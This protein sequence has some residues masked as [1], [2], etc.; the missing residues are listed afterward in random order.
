ML[1]IW[2]TGR[3]LFDPLLAIVVAILIIKTSFGLLAKAFSPLLDASLPLEEE[4]VIK[5]IID[6]Y[7]G[8][9]VGFH[10]LRTRKAGSERH[11]DL[12]LVVPK[13]QNIAVSH[14][15]CDQIEQAV[16]AQYPEAHVLIHVEPCREGDDCLSC[17]VSCGS[18]KGDQ[19]ADTGTRDRD[20]DLVSQTDARP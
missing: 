6:N 4:D 7:G 10:K 19:A 3:S 2:L 5:Q 12:H 15:L 11:I 8:Q 14:G 17:P 9:Y 20:G 13:N 1:L 16:N 18:V